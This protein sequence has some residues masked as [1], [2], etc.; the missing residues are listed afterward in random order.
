MTTLKAFLQ[1]DRFVKHCGIGLVSLAP[2]H[3]VTRMTVQLWHFN[4]VG[5]VQGG[6]TFTLADYAFVMAANTHGTVTVG[7]NISITY[8]NPLLIF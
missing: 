6:A 7:S 1:G 4:S 8:L 5:L 2:G 3:A